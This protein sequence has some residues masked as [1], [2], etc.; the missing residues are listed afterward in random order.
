MK[1]TDA[2]IINRWVDP[3]IVKLLKL[4]I[5][6][7]CMSWLLPAD[8]LSHVMANLHY[9]SFL[10][11]VPPE[12]HLPSVQARNWHPRFFLS[13]N[14]TCTLLLNPVHV[15]PYS[16]NDLFI[17]MSTGLFIHPNHWDRHFTGSPVYTFIASNWSFILKSENVDLIKFSA[18]NSSLAS[19]AK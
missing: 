11:M 18:H 15:I 8:L 1:N 10:W 9:S 14:P 13:P 7:I 5:L 3:K 12:R 16:W 19:T 17:S 2:A 6:E 4:P